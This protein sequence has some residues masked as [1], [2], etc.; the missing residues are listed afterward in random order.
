MVNVDYVLVIESVWEQIKQVV[1]VDMDIKR[2]V[3]T[4]GIYNECSVEVY[5]KTFRLCSWDASWS[6][7]RLIKDCV[8]SVVYGDH[9]NAGSLNSI[10]K[11]SLDKGSINT[12]LM[13]KNW[14]D[15]TEKEGPTGLMG[16]DST[17]MESMKDNAG[18]WI[19]LKSC[20]TLSDIWRA[21]DA[22]LD[23]EVVLPNFK[24]GEKRRV[25][26][27]D[28][29]EFEMDRWRAVKDGVA[30]SEFVVSSEL[31]YLLVEGKLD[32]SYMSTR[33]KNKWR[34]ELKIDD[35]IDARDA[36]MNWYEGR[37]VDLDPK[38]KKV[39]VHY[40]GWTEKWDA[41]VNVEGK[42]IAKLYSV[43]EDWRSG[44]RPSD[45]I[46]YSVKIGVNESLQW[47]SGKVVRVL[48][49]QR[50]VVVRQ[51]GLLREDAE[52]NIFD[53]SSE[54]I[55]KSGTHIKPKYVSSPNGYENAMSSYCYH[56]K[57]RPN[58]PG[59]V[60]LQ[61]LG[62]TCFM[63]SMI[64]CLSNS[65]VLSKYFIDDNYRRDL[66][67]NNPLGM[68]GKVAEA[69]AN[70]LVSMWSGKYTTMYP[71]ELKSI[72][73]QYAPQFAGYAQ[74]DSQE[75]MSFLLDGLHEDLN[76]VKNKP[77]VEMKDFNGTV[78]DKQMA[79][80]SWRNH[81]ARN[82]SVVVDNCMAQLRS[83]ITCPVC[84]HQSIT[85]DPYMSLSV[86]IPTKST[87]ALKLQLFWAN[88][89]VPT[90]FSVVVEKTVNMKI[91]KSELGKL[92]NLESSKLIMLEVFSHR[93]TRIIDDQVN[94]LTLRQTEFDVY[95]LNVPLQK[96]VL[97]FA[98][99][100]SYSNSNGYYNVNSAMDDEPAIGP[101][102]GN[103]KSMRLVSVLHRA[104]SPH[105]QNDTSPK[106]N[107]GTYSPNYADIKS[108]QRRIDLFGTPSIVA[109]PIKCTNNEV[110]DKI[111]C[112]VK[113]LLLPTTDF[114]SENPPYTIGISNFNGSKMYVDE[115]PHND[116]DFRLPQVSSGFFT[117]ALQW[118]AIGYQQG[119]REDEAERVVMHDSMSKL[120]VTGD[121]KV[122]SL[123]SCIVKFTEKEQ[124]GEN[125][126]WYC[127]KC[128]EH[129]RAFK[130][131]DL[132]SL[133]HILIVHLKRFRYVQGQ[134]SMQ[135]RDKIDAKVEF[136]IDNLD[137]KSYVL[138]P[139]IKPE[140]CKY[141]LFAVSEHS[142][143][144]GGGHYTAIAK[145]HIS[146]K[147]YDFNDST[148]TET[149][150]NRA[151]SS[152]S[153]VLFYERQVKSKSSSSMDTI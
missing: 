142:G 26:Y 146:N 19:Q 119:Y 73:G 24:V 41:W 74:H 85:F 114:S 13:K 128:K 145:N 63:N 46:E 3:V 75:F 21:L 121:E 136:P 132:W 120:H 78:P 64:Q 88:G 113:R 109:I 20:D 149:N 5:P 126:T 18:I 143:G 25:C 66:N 140:D 47:R 51:V 99:T 124:L 79:D 112:V 83:H 127:P 101:N 15:E 129:R 90:K 29:D 58:V 110:Y 38:N 33:K 100:G 135:H 48:V 72:I 131:F 14:I 81:K 89:N 137:M 6:N 39:L 147:W 133:P 108:K 107:N 70:L 94:L 69:Y 151:I 53:L 76:R 57:G 122:L 22:E 141:N 130:K 31:P 9:A 118:S 16:A 37:V 55:C 61:N 65:P 102:P 117:F 148:V 84:Q 59:A 52:T 68:G 42:E 93:V 97:A 87:I 98:M 60:G 105:Q 28:E 91:V 103:D 116:E 12:K 4:K 152:M 139:D 44:L 96:H 125:N 71:S 32:G 54:S 1:N 111:W 23:M 95:E 104:P 56:H 27:C 7:V 50:K 40:L 86:P 62:N 150:P 30:V 43:V 35:M 123:D 80:E 8:E 17:C 92:C 2:A 106:Q 49:D 153:Y 10:C 115:I 134:Y 67:R 77:Y 36:Q 45:K 11:D 138:N 82:Q 34:Y 144:L